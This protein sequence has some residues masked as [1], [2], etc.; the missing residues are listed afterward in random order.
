M[1]PYKQLLVLHTTAGYDHI[2]QENSFFFDSAACSLLKVP[3]TAQ[4]M[5]MR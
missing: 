5:E 2:L 3:T 1:Q 4:N